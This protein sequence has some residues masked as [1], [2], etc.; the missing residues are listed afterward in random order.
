MVGGRGDWD[1]TVS[2]SHLPSGDIAAS[3]NMWSP[4]PRPLGTVRQLADDRVEGDA[5]AAVVR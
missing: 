2:A 1:A 5:I 4:G 3:P